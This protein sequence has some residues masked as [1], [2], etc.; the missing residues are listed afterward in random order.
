MPEGVV[1]GEEMKYEI[2]FYN[3]KR[4]LKGNV[5]PVMLNVDIIEDN[6]SQN[7]FIIDR[8]SQKIEAYRKGSGTLRV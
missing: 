6:P 2:R 3:N 1:I 4:L 5:D 7:A 8:L